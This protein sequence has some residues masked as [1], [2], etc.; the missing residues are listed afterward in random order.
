MTEAILDATS[1]R[2]RPIIIT[3][4]VMIFGALP[5]VFSSNIFYL[6]RQNLGIT[7]I[8]GLIVGTLFSLFVVPLVYILLKNKEAHQFKFIKDPLRRVVQINQ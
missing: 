6:S 1:Q 3:T 8:G 2:F 5:L 4:L 7:I